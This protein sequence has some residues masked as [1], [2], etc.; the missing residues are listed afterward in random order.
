MNKTL[1]EQRLDR[2]IEMLVDVSFKVP[3]ESLVAISINGLVFTDFKS[4]FV[5]GKDL[6]EFQNF[7][8]SITVVPKFYETE[9]MTD[10]EAVSELLGI[11]ID[12]LLSSGNFGFEHIFDLGYFNI[13]F[14]LRNVPDCPL[15]GELHDIIKVDDLLE[16][17]AVQQRDI[18][19]T[20]ELSDYSTQRGLHISADGQ[21]ASAMKF[22]VT[23]EKHSFEDNATY[24][25]RAF[26]QLFTIHGLDFINTDDV[27]DDSDI[28]KTIYK[29]IAS[30][31]SDQSIME[32][33]DIDSEGS[34]FQSGRK[35]HVIKIGY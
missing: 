13:N 2:G 12:Q 14:T 5:V 27:N 33:P 15:A 4:T 11:Q 17:V 6:V 20:V 24:L 30:I 21:T 3:V 19:V 9:S 32:T 26:K 29:D 18:A 8:N 23:G 34:Y 10:E 25:K 31:F 1:L 22:K 7:I 16:S 28:I 35:T